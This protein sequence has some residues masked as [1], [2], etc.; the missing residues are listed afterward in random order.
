MGR[1]KTPGLIKRAG[2]WHV[3]KQ[4]GGQR[5]RQSTGSGQLAEAELFLA[6]LIDETRQATIYGVRPERSFEQAAAKFVL[7]NQHK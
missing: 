4:I 7:E 5:I 2:I 1:K 6:K 3:D